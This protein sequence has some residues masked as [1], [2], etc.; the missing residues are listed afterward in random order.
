MSETDATASSGKSPLLRAL[1]LLAFIADSREP[2]TLMDL[3][4]TL[5]LPKPTCYRLARALESAGFV[6]KDPLTRRYHVG[7]SFED[8]ALSGLRHSAA[9]GRRRQLM[10]DLTERLTARVNLVVLKAGNLSFVEWVDSTAPLRVEIKAGMPMPVHC[11][12]SGKLLLALGPPELGERVLRSAPFERYTKN[13]ITDARTLMRKLDAV[14]RLGYAVD[15]EELLTGV[16]CLAVPVFN[17]AGATVAALA[18]M[19]PV[20]IHPL[21]ALLQRLPEIKACA[22]AISA[23]LGWRPSAR[24]ARSP[25]SP[26]TLPRGPDVLA[27]VAGKGKTNSAKL[28]LRSVK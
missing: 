18:V 4:R 12:A 22:A 10:N 3:S 28:S 7:S 27:A 13:T 1:R 20:A 6:Q 5:R 16:N 23:D 8:L 25:R 17:R 14:R 26:A 19:A 15:C 21:D 24:P 2:L 11:S 9:H